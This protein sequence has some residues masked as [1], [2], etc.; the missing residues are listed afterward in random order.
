VPEFRYTARAAD[1]KLTEGTLAANDRAAAIAQIEKQRCFP[2]RI[3]PLGEARPS[4]ARPQPSDA[5]A[6]PAPA[7]KPPAAAAVPV[8]RLSYGHQHLFTEQLAHLLSAGMTLDESLAIL[9]KRLGH[10]KLRA[11]C[12]GL[13]RAL[14]DGRSLSQALRDFPKSFTPLYTNMVAAGEA[15]GTLAEILRRL[16]LHLAEV[17][18]LRDRVQMALV[19]PSVLV[20]AG[21]GLILIFMT[22][23]VPQ[24]TGFFEQTGQ[25][26]PTATKILL[27]ANG[28][29]SGYWWVAP[30]AA[31]AGWAILRSVKANP[32]TRRAWD[33]FTLSIP[34]VG[35]IRRFSFYAQ[36]ARTLGTLTENGITLLRA[37]ELLEEISGNEWI[38]TK[39][40]ETRAAVMDGSS[41]S[42]ALA[43][44]GIF[45]P[46]YL[47]MMAVGE[48]TGRFSSTMTM[49]ADVYERELDKQ[50]K[51]VSTLIPPVIM[52][53]IAVIV[54]LVVYGILSAVFNLTSGL[55][56]RVR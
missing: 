20:F 12:T 42:N 3:E 35:R 25:E 11:L 40:A 5:P 41:L 8:N 32:D 6:A 29:I 10:P 19:Y 14:V 50:V 27:A 48:Q 30:L 18:S 56:T 36:F 45:P 9:A 31:A 13:H 54:G 49:V 28:V 24:L 38:R 4:K 37:L 52:I 51:I 39:M 53:V 34:G 47:D 44:H 17:K 23:M 2:V 1:G 46:I 15:S 16:T 7:A 22:V 33:R 26:L 43:R 55:K 21:I